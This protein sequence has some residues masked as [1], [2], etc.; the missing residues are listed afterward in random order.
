[1]EMKLSCKEQCFLT[2]EIGK[3]LRKSLIMKPIHKEEEFLSF[4]F[5]VSKTLIFP[6]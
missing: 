6:G 4:I 1:M 5:L 3:L 2:K